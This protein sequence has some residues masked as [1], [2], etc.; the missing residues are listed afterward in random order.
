MRNGS[1]VLLGALAAAVFA[2]GA[3]ET[4]AQDEIPLEFGTY[5]QQRDWCRENRAN[6]SGPDYTEKRAFINLSATEINWNQTA[7]KITSVSVDG[8][9]INLG[10]TMTTN[11]TTETKTLPLIRKNK[12]TFVL[13]GI[14]F[15]H[16]SEYQP[17]PWLG[18]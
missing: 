18:H 14:N 10:V 11:G 15:F 13:T 9:K 12:K 17:N 2:A 16:C 6:Q 1:T 5:S 3:V 8:N 7:G 4:R